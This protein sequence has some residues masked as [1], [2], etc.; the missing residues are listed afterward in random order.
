MSVCLSVT[1]VIH[2]YTVQIIEINFTLFDRAMFLVSGS[3]I[4]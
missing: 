3:E 1:L 2:A 4:S